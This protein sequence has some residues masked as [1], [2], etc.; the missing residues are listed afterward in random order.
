MG[1]NEYGKVCEGENWMGVE[2]GL[3]S[4]SERK[5]GGERRRAKERRKKK[6]NEEEEE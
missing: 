2:I 3:R 1:V 5:R 6:N 4:R